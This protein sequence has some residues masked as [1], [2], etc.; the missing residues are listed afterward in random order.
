MLHVGDR[1][2]HHEDMLNKR[3]VSQ[4]RELP[5]PMVS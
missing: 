1:H 4:N 2:N 3:S 5:Y